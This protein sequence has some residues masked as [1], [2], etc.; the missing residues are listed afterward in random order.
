MNIKI[1]N[2]LLELRK[3]NG[4]SQEQL[5]D[6][7][8]I[9]RQAVSKWERAEASPDMDNLIAL[10]KLY[11]VSIDS[12]L[13]DEDDQSNEKMDFDV[14]VV[15]EQSSKF[16]KAFLSAFPIIIV[17]IYLIL[18]GLFSLWHPGWLVFLL[19]PVI[20]SLFEAIKHK[21]P[22][23]FCF[24]VLIVII[25]LLLGFEFNLWHPF[26]FLFILIPVYYVICDV[27]HKNK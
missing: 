19:I 25:Y 6:E 24:P 14:E 12:L 2:R 1:A 22:E 20:P 5:A 27:I 17:L 23:E 3:E 7:L 15:E 4:Y 13:K 10:S 8:G 11:N 16:T 18:G 21:N 9:S 26:W